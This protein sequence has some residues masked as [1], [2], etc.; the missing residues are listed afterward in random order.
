VLRR[1]EGGSNA[2]VVHAHHGY[3]TIGNVFAL[4]LKETTHAALL[5]ALPK[6]IVGQDVHGLEGHEIP[7]LD[8]RILALKNVDT[9][10]RAKRSVNDRGEISYWDGDHYFTAWDFNSKF[11]SWL[12]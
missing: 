5:M 8:T 9:V 11:Y 2:L 10:F 4:V 7:I 6:S 3:G 12:D 1:L